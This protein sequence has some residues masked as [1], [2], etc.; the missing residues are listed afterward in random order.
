MTS[1]PRE[2]PYQLLSGEQCW[3]VCGSEYPLHVRCDRAAG[4]DGDHAMWTS[5]GVS[6]ILRW[7]EVCWPGGKD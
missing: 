2:V 5:D 7:T 6:L 3:A 1:D 4:H